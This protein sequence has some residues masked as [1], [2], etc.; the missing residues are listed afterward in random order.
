[1]DEVLDHVKRP[2]LPWRDEQLTECGKRIIDVASCVTRDEV[3]AKVKKQGKQ[4]AAMSTCMTCWQTTARHRDWAASPC[5][6]IARWLEKVSWA[7]RRTG[8]SLM[9]RRDLSRCGRALIG[10]SSG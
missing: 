1:M 10:R 6:V 2:P 7:E 8:N 3:I 9:D 4:R 5:D